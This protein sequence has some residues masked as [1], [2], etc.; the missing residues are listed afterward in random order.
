MYCPECKLK[1]EDD[2]K[3]YCPVCGGSL[4]PDENARLDKPIDF[5]PEELGLQP[6]PEKNDGCDENDISALAE[7][8][9]DEDIDTEIEGVL[10]EAFSLEKIAETDRTAENGEEGAAGLADLQVE[11]VE[12]ALA[13][14]FVQEPET[15]TVVSG[16]AAMAEEP[17]DEEAGDKFS[18]PRTPRRRFSL[19]WPALALIVIGVGGWF[20]WQEPR[21]PVRPRPQ[22]QAVP[23]VPD[24]RLSEKND[25]EKE[26]PSVQLPESR[27]RKE[28]AT[29]LQS[30]ERP[31]AM[32][33]VAVEE[34][35]PVPAVQTAHEESTAAVS[36]TPLAASPVAQAVHEK[37]AAAT[38]TSVAATPAPSQREVAVQTGAPRAPAARYVVHCGS[39][40]SLE[41]A[42][43]QAERL[44][45]KGFSV[46]VRK[47]SLKRK[48][49]WWRVLVA[50]GD[51]LSAARRTRAK[52]G[53]SF[54]K[55]GTRIIRNGR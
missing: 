18:S 15:A 13:A 28:T 46:F 2:S 24:R 54:P 39:F 42:R 35:Q 21:K 27:E 14:A 40:R 16:S 6:V 19:L 44:R 36:K 50:G 1:I 45:R 53:Q 5:N 25:A 23:M 8:W 51:T 32:E 34:E 10:A 12:E 20:F 11:E 17:G 7:L 48:G 43:V 47:V 22:L 52:I 55:E 31:I 3:T 38:K 29:T 9:R 49:V 26:S 30:A 33:K 4:L 41:R 37:S